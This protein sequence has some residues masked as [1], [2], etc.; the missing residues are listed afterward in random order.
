MT[1]AIEALARLQEE[2]AVTA[3]LHWIDMA[4]W[5]AASVP[6]REWLIRDR[7]PIRQPT[8]LSGEGAVGK[9]IVTLHLLVAVALGRDWIGTLP[10]PGG[11]WYVG[12]EDDERELHI[13]LSAI[14]KHFGASYA[15]LVAGGFRMTSLFGKDA[16]LG[17]PNRFGVIEPTPLYRRLYDEAAEL[18]PKCIALDASADMFAGSEIDRSQVRQFVGLLR[19]LADVCDGAVI[20]LSHPSLTGINSGTGLSGST[21]WHNSVRA[22]M[23]LTSPK[24]ENGEQP[25]TDLRELS[26]KKNNY[27]PIGDSIVLRYK[28]GLFLPET[29]TSNLEKLARESVV[30]EILITVGKSLESRGDWLSASRQSHAYAPRIIVQQQEAKARRIKKHEL[31]ASLDRQLDQNK[32]HIETIKPGTARERRVIRFEPGGDE[33]QTQHSGTAASKRLP[34]AVC[35]SH[36]P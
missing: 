25:D 2:R 17:M 24:A 7:V 34:A 23:Y 16:V 14:Q 33:S 27:G 28:N 4:N 32:V 12:A 29:G 13:R 3:E 9:S 10:E 35:I 20:L 6:E 1:A 19:K 18:K 31:A 5:D 11:A 36:P 30:D 26:F 21:A 8:L 22:R 15:D